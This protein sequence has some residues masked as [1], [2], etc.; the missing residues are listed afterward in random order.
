MRVQKNKKS[1]CMQHSN[2]NNTCVNTKVKNTQYICIQNIRFT[3]ICVCI[4]YIKRDTYQNIHG[5]TNQNLHDTF[6]KKIPYIYIF[7]ENNQYICIPN[8]RYKR[9]RLQKN[10]QYIRM[11]NSNKNITCVNTKVKNNQ[12]MCI[13]NIRYTHICL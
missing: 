7:S 12:Y 9:M 8:I 13:Q 1:I 6:I 2:K 10:N 11:Q 3:H 5:D 4:R